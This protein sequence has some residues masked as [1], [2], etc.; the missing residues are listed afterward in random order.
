[1]NGKITGIGIKVKKNADMTKFED[2]LYKIPD[3][4]VVS[5]AQVKSTIMSLVSTAKVLVLSI[6]L[7][8][9]LIAMAGVVNTILMSVIERYQEIGI[10]KSM[11]ALPLDIF[12]MIWFETGILC[13]LGSITGTIGALTLSAVTEFLVRRLLPYAPTGALIQITPGL[14][15]FTIVSIV[16][17]GIISGIYPSW[18]AAKIRP[19]E[20]IRKESE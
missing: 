20:A 3:V 6:A 14:V 16:V 2:K 12:K 4:Q 7:I 5:M 18:L 15:V 1:M 17:L 8:A 9:I 19:L 11:G 13:L 10:I